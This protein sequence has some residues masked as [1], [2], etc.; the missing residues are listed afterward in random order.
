MGYHAYDA[1]LQTLRLLVVIRAAQPSAFSIVGERTAQSVAHVIAEGGNA[2]HLRNVSLHGKQ[3]VGHGTCSC[4][5]ALAIDE[6]GGVY[7]I[8]SLSYLVHSLYV[9]D[10]HE[11][12]AEPVDMILVDPVFNALNHEQPHHWLLR[13]RLVAAAGAVGVARRRTVG[14]VGYLTVV[15][16]R[17][18]PLEVG[19]VYVVGVVI[20]HVEDDADASLVKSLNHLLELT[21]AHLGLIGVGGVAALG[22]VVVHWVIAPVE[23]RLVEA[24]LIDR[25]IVIA[26]KDVDGVYA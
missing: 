15:V 3:L 14:N 4:A 21:N 7:G 5:P 20:D 11:V 26:R 19:T 10:A 12:E 2:W 17:K 25:S 22:H 24:C 23:L 8:D 18:S 16:V 13:S 9:V 6:D 1:S